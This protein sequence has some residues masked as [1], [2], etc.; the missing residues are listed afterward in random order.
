MN[1]PSR[2]NNEPQ[3]PETP[4]SSLLDDSAAPPP[5]QNAALPPKAQTPQQ[6]ANTTGSSDDKTAS[7]SEK[8][9]QTTDGKNAGKNAGNQGTDKHPPAD[10]TASAN[11][12][13]TQTVI[14]K[15]AAQCKPNSGKGAGKSDDSKT[16]DGKSSD[17]KSAEA[18]KAADGATLQTAVAA[19]TPAP[20]APA[21]VIAAPVMAAAVGVQ[22]TPA[23]TSAAVCGPVG[24]DVVGLK[25]LKDASKTPGKPST[26]AAETTPDQAASDNAQTAPASGNDKPA[27]LATTDKDAI[28]TDATPKDGSAHGDA[29]AA[30]HHDLTQLETPAPSGLDANSAAG[31][32][33]PQTQQINPT[34]QQ[35]PNAASQPPSG[36]MLTQPA[37]PVAG[38]AVEIA[39]R[40][41]AG[42]NHFE[43]R[44]DP[45]DLGRIDVHL[46]VDRDGQVTSHLVV[47]HP[48]T[49]D[50]LRR[51]ST[52][53]ERALQDA[54]L[55]TSDNGLQFSLRDQTMNQSGN[56]NTP[57]NLARV[58]I[59]DDTMSVI[60]PAQRIY[61]RLAGLVSGLD[62]SV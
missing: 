29:G 50:L 22:A 37:I 62:I 4:F 8:S 3:Q 28:V 55:K 51:D 60:E 27:H 5:D 30:A 25:L 45:P 34:Q 36:Q 58:F 32:G 44:L 13:S 49:L 41:L 21:A 26:D 48:D 17:E 11:P 59:P 9:G 24:A 23:D 61:S 35:V 43:I 10:Q 42:K 52:G 7:S 39:G 20:T 46:S 53:L 15:L 38:L 56:T 2:L 14:G 33:S 19:T 40:A 47:D 57:P 54:G 6:T 31:G 18:C 12:S 16:T 1:V